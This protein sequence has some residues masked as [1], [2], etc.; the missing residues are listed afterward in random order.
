M[1][2]RK[3]IIIG[4]SFLLATP[5]LFG[6]D[7]KKDH[8]DLFPKAGDYS[9]GI[10][11]ANVIKFVGN[12]F[13]AHGTPDYPNYSMIE[14]SMTAVAIKPIIYGRYFITD[15]MATR[16]RLGVGV[17]NTTSRVYLYDDVANIDNPLNDDP[18]TY[19]KTVD[20]YKQR[21]SEFEL[22]IGV[23]WR[24]NLWRMQGYG[25]VEVMGAYIHRRAS[26]TYGNAMSTTNETPTTYNF[27]NNTIQTPTHRTI[28][29]KGGNIFHFGAGLYA[30]ADFFI[31]KNISIGAEFNLFIF[32][33]VST[34]Q[35]GIVETYKLDQVYTGETKL[36]PVNTGFHTKPLGTFNI[37]VYF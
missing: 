18:L 37:C 36:N 21:N 28:D 34:E 33:S 10:D 24:K 12:S 30:G 31:T 27:F 22:G 4:I 11:M 13:S 7:E 19:E 5:I 29:T 25:G 1:K 20:Q 8:S 26:H 32:G 23:E 2:M 14:P 35:T 17:N 9:L 16:I 3:F 15:N 6:Q